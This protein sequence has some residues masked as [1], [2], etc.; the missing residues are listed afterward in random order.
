V[1]TL[2]LNSR[3]IEP[4]QAPGTLRHLQVAGL[5]F[6]QPLLMMCLIIADPKFQ[7]TCPQL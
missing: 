1:K 6:D 4:C 2:R 5:V 3:H 7:A